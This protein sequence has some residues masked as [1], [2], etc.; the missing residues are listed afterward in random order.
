MEKTLLRLNDKT[1][2]N[3]E[4]KSIEFLQVGQRKVSRFARAS[5]ISALANESF[6][7]YI[8][9]TY[10]ALSAQYLCAQMLLL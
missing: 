8:I 4:V 10:V 6:T 3:G 1:Y 5:L 9:H 2:S 7:R